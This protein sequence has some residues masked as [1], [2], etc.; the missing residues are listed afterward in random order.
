MATAITV[1]RLPAH[2]NAADNYSNYSRR[3]SET[4][5]KP[6]SMIPFRRDEEFVERRSILDHL[7]QACPKPGSRTALIGVGGVGKTQLAI[8]HAYRIRAASGPRDQDLWVFWVPAGTR[9]RVE[10]AFKS[11]ADTVRIPGRNQPK[12]NVLQL[13]CQWLQ[14][15][16]HGP[17]LLV[18]DGADDV[19]TF[20]SVAEKGPRTSDI[21]E[22]RRSLST[23][24][25]Q[26]SHGSILITTRNKE[27]ASKL[28]S[29]G[30]TIIEVG[31]MDQDR[32]L[33][34]LEVKSRSQ[35]D[36]SDGLKL[37]EV[38][39][40][41]PL[42][43]SQAA[44]Y[45][46]HTTP[47]TSVMEYL[48]IFRKQQLSVIQPDD[49][50]IQPGRDPVATTWQIAFDHIRSIR[51]SAAELL[52]FMSFFDRQGIPEPLLLG[53]T[54]KNG[55]QN[56]EENKNDTS[57]FD[58]DI[59]VLG[60]YGLVEINE[61]GDVFGL[62]ELVQSSIRSWLDAQG[63][64]EKF[65]KQYV[66]RMAHAFPTGDF[67]NQAVCQ[68]LFPHVKTVIG[69]H[70]V[71]KDTLRD[72]ALLLYNGSW[73]ALEQGIYATAETMAKRSI[74]IRKTV[75]GPDHPVTLVSLENLAS[76]YRNQQRLK[77]TEALELE[78]MNLRKTTLGQNHADTLTSMANLAWTYKK[79]DRVKEAESLFSQVMETRK[80]VFG[81][82]D[83][84]TLSSMAHLASVYRS[85]GR[86]DEAASL[87]KQVVDTRET[88]LG[89]DHPETLASMA[90]LASTYWD[91]G[92]W[93][94]AEAL[95]LRVME[96]R[97]RTLGPDHLLT[98]TAMANLAWTYKKQGRWKDAQPL[99]LQAMETRRVI[100]GPDHHLTLASMA[101]LATSYKNQGK[102]RD[103]EP[104]EIHVME[105]RRA[106]LGPHHSDTL[107][108]MTHLAST[109][110]G[111]RRWKEVEALEV[112]VMETR[113]RVLG[114]SDP[115]T[116]VC[117]SNLASTYK[118]QGRW[119]EAEAIDKQVLENRKTVLG[120]EH[121]DTLTSMANLA[122]TYW[123]QKRWKE[124][125][126]LEVR[127][128]ETR[129]SVL[130]PDHPLTLTSMANLAL[131][132]N[133]QGRSHDAFELIE[134]CSQARIRVL[135][136]AH[137]DTQS[138]LLTT[139]QWRALAGER[140]Q[141]EHRRDWKKKVVSI[142]TKF[143]KSG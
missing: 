101:N 139:Q 142:R 13:V 45:I 28:T 1:G 85:Q 37:I 90:S 59:A 94:E 97:E 140:E 77:E 118:K 126:P 36:Q 39:R 109:Y 129:K 17:W 42:A 4:L 99:E 110:W 64:V 56:A 40:G 6:S 113:K 5:P 115:I 82:D 102:W 137:P 25:P 22:E 47:H 132:W 15:K 21:G 58:K 100:L 7:H 131:T 23:Y 134:E 55:S 11:I 46:R 93:S 116:L 44:A 73:Y 75:L 29:S 135:G 38:L 106:I 108:S 66:S 143:H 19:N 117:M 26:D 53:G 71:D 69:Y 107:V 114:S 18:L 27:L 84:S 10:D 54:K 86:L 133:S 32:A 89:P 70:P 34:L 9:A 76:A 124:A 130:G 41:M 111:Q 60:D 83:P 50:G 78:V 72:L 123:D 138:A 120:E 74:D 49:G 30:G 2:E 92:Q 121:P 14:E 67:R 20:Y 3:R 80:T 33:A 105:T 51:P 104:L 112:V 68:K 103:A 12:A 122:S 57:A 24:L 35:F 8:E 127:V 95:E 125:E 61:E 128:L 87:F 81:P 96:T 79:Q 119:K 88:V 63:E 91:Q 141:K 52:S 98:A 48:G 31:P 136:P 65:R 43:I 62:H 16:R